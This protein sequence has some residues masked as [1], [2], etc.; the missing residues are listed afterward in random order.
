MFDIARAARFR[1]GMI[2]KHGRK[3]IDDREELT[4]NEVGKKGPA[5]YAQE[6]P[7]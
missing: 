7:R 6:R 2:Q 1:W 4:G 5:C 3:A